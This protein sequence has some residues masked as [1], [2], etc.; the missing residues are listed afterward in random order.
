M[1]AIL[2][3]RGILAASSEPA[4]KYTTTISEKEV[5]QE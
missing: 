3:E 2:K 4:Q 1:L 5:I